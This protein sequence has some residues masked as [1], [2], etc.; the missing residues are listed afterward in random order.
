MADGRQTALDAAPQPVLSILVLTY[1]Q[2]RFL[3]PCIESALSARLDRPDDIEVVILDDG[4]DDGTPKVGR[5]L[6]TRHPGRVR[7][8]WQE[9]TGHIPRNFNRLAALARG[10]FLLLFAGDDAFPPGWPAGGRIARMADDPALALTLVDGDVIEASGTP[11]GVRRQSERTMDLLRRETSAT[12]L[13]DHLERRPLDLFLQAAIV[14]RSFFDRIG[15]YDEALAADDS[16]MA[17]RLFRGLGPA[18]MHHGVD[19]GLGFFYRKHDGNLHRDHLRGLR[20]KV[21][22]YAREID[23]AHHR[24]FFKKLL[25]NLS[26]LSWQQLASP[27]VRS[28]LADGLGRGPARRLLWRAS[29]RKIRHRA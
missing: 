16:A 17:L 2:A 1:R 24:N 21:E 12:V 27:E 28:L 20:R 23:P 18:G 15:G 7:Y 25:W 8:V 22:F 29:L 3:E 10:E 4:S 6:E 13:H 9:N 26:R 11:T 14:R 19:D 5:M